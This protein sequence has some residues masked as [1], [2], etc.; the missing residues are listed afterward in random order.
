MPRTVYAT[1]FM[2]IKNTFYAKD[3]FLARYLFY[4]IYLFF[5][6]IFLHWKKKEQIRERERGGR[7]REGEI[8]P[9]RG[10]TGRSSRTS[11]VF[12]LA[13]KNTKKKKTI[14]S[15][16]LT[17]RF[18]EDEC[19]RLYLFVFII[20]SLVPIPLDLPWSGPQCR[21]CGGVPSD[22]GSLLPWIVCIVCIVHRY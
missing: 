1:W 3:L 16:A 14:T 6:P 7:G 20:S 22:R 21:T 19:R 18:T 13:V 12:I 5:T 15:M 10:R 9:S 4:F 11:S 2:I 17:A 8:K